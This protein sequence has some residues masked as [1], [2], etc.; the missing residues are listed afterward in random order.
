M[1]IFIASVAASDSVCTSK[2]LK[3][4]GLVGY[5]RNVGVNYRQHGQ[6]RIVKTLDETHHS[7]VVN[8]IYISSRQSCD[9]LIYKWIFYIACTD[10]PL[11]CCMG[12]GVRWWINYHRFCS[13]CIWMDYFTNEKQWIIFA[14]YCSS[15]YKSNIVFSLFNGSNI[16]FHNMLIRYLS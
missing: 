10:F 4:P 1:Q 3:L 7:W 2:L 13:A 16:P 15:T 12:I 8:R 11:S 5:H 6:N 9:L 14:V